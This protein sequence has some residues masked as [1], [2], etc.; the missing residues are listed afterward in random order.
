LNKLPKVHKEGTL[1]PPECVTLAQE[2]PV[3]VTFLLFMS[4]SISRLLSRHIKSVG[5]PPKKIPSFLWPVKDNLGLK[6][7]DV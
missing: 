3:S 7:P 1:D 5:L 6:T 2:K 4:M